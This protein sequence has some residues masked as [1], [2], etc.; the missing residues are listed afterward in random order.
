MARKKTVSGSAADGSRAMEERVVA[1][2]QQLGRLVGTVERKTTGWL[3][4]AALS[5]QVTRIRD[6]AA[7]LLGHLGGGAAAS[8]D[9]A[10]EMPGSIAESPAPDAGSRA[11]GKAS[12]G[13]G[14][15][16]A[17]PR[18]A[19]TSRAASTSSRSRE[20]AA[21]PGKTHRKPPTSVVEAKDTDEEIAKASATDGN[22]R[23]R[24]R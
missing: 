1:F 21:A 9:E 20:H 14:R 24:G 23:T 11:S 10:I 16:P 18:R 5:D 12:K 4:M 22:R 15:K 2:A 13:R 17:S 19:A 6:G 8:H 3:D 7:D